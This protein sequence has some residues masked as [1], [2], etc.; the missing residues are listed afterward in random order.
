MRASFFACIAVGIV[1]FIGGCAGAGAYG[2]AP[3]YAPLGAEET[4]AKR[5]P[6]SLFGVVTARAAG[7]GGA[8]HITVT[9]R[10]LEPSNVCDKPGEDETCRVTVSDRDFGM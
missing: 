1:V 3:R 8:A 6:S 7:A 2:H 10:K 5:H 4:A 9:V